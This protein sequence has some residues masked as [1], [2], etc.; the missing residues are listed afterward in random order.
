MKPCDVPTPSFE[1]AIHRPDDAS[2]A[3]LDA[4][5]SLPLSY[6]NVHDLT[7]AF[8]RTDYRNEWLERY[9]SCVD[10]HSDLYFLS[11]PRDKEFSEGSVTESL[12]VENMGAEQSIWVER[13]IGTENC[14]TTCKLTGSFSRCSLNASVL[15]CDVTANANFVFRPLPLL[16]DENLPTETGLLEETTASEDPVPAAVN[17]KPIASSLA[18][19]SG[20]H[21]WDQPQPDFGNGAH[22]ACP[23]PSGARQSPSAPESISHLHQA[24]LSNVGDL[25][26]SEG[27]HAVPQWIP[28]AKQNNNPVLTPFAESPDTNGNSEG[29]LSFI[30]TDGRLPSDA[31]LSQELDQ[32]TTQCIEEL[33][34]VILAACLTFIG[35]STLRQCTVS[36][37][38]SGNASWNV[39]TRQ[40]HSRSSATNSSKRARQQDDKDEADDGRSKRPNRTRGPQ[41]GDQV[42]QSFL[43]AHFGCSIRIT[44]P[45]RIRPRRHIAIVR[46]L[47]FEIYLDSSSTSIESMPCR[48]STACV[49]TTS[50]RHQKTSSFMPG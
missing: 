22:L 42:R 5:H 4:G 27:L 17:D 37:S 50:L 16:L 8:T 38:N 23:L 40:S 12:F 48:S 33:G 31:V 34:N 9:H 46:S 36:G 32:K 11:M 13:S 26:T 49:A 35:S 41:P 10:N 29:E 19:D 14:S 20:Y 6:A 43:R 18:S 30:G 25:H 47:A 1:E 2:E 7:H 3:S 44:T 21:T 15:D 39:S 28:A 45:S 24:Q